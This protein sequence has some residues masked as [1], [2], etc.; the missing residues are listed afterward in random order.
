M[1]SNE[2]NAEILKHVTEMSYNG[3]KMVDVLRIWYTHSDVPI[4]S[5]DNHMCMGDNQKVVNKHIHTAVK[6]L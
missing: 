4:Y 3:Y 1:H 5:S 2:S 6:R